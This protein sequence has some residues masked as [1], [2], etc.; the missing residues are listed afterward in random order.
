MF[1]D[2]GVVRGTITNVCGHVI[3]VLQGYIAMNTATTMQGYCQIQR[4]KTSYGIRLDA[5]VEGSGDLAS[6][7]LLDNFTMTGSFPNASTSTTNTTT[8]GLAMRQELL[9]KENSKIPST[10]PIIDIT[11]LKNGE[12][13]PDGWEIISST[14][15]D[16]SANLNQGNNNSNTIYLAIQRASQT[17]TTTSTSR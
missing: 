4:E 2:V 10:Q 8:S 16:A 9:I 15:N 12:A 3:G 7:Y 13:A 14:L 17:D 11:I 1:E 5:K 6:C